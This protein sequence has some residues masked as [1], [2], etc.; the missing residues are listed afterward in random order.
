M[1]LKTKLAAAKIT[2]NIPLCKLL[3]ETVK[4]Q[5]QSD[6]ALAADD[7][8]TVVLLDNYVHLH[9]PNSII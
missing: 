3:Y 2:K 4:K 9:I 6:V 5:G 7:F 1:E 8:D